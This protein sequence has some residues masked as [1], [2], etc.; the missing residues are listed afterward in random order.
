MTVEQVVWIIC[1]ISVL[2]AIGSLIWFVIY[3]NKMEKRK[4]EIIMRY[5]ENQLKILM[6]MLSENNSEDKK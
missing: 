5:H 1:T 2:F 3:W 6:K 4:D